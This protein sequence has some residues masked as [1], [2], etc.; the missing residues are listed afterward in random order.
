[1]SLFIFEQT[2]DNLQHSFG[3][4][5]F[6]EKG[7]NSKRLGTDAFIIIA[8]ASEDDDGQVLVLPHGADVLE[9][10]NA[11]HA[12]H[13]NIENGEIGAFFMEDVKR[14]F[15]V[16]GGEGFIPGF[17]EGVIENALIVGFVINDEDAG[18]ALG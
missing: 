9:Q 3:T 10:S 13:G 8:A 5:R 15:A 14:G 4:G 17:V 7:L 2:A 1:M 18:F 11:V 6:G 16:P 12:G